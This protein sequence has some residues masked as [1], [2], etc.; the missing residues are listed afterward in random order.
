MRRVILFFGLCAASLFS[1]NAKQFS[2]RQ[3]ERMYRKAFEYIMNDF[4]TDKDFYRDSKMEDQPFVVFP[5]FVALSNFWDYYPFDPQ[6]PYY[7]V[8]TQEPPFCLYNSTGFDN[9][10]SK[11]GDNEKSHFIVGFTR[12][13]DDCFFAEVSYIDRGW[14]RTGLSVR[15]GATSEMLTKRGE[16]WESLHWF[17]STKTYRF[18]FD[19]RGHLKTVESDI[20]H[21]D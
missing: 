21:F 10:R 9:F 18:I 19:K 1:L 3:Y 12:C 6:D 2:I 16:E 13:K 20:Q 7:E 5:R 4:E 17:N 15:K 14:H 8:A 11:T